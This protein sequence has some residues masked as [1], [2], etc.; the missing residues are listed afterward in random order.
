MTIIIA[1]FSLGGL[2]GEQLPIH[3]DGLADMS[4]SKIKLSPLPLQNHEPFQSERQVNPPMLDDI[5]IDEHANAVTKHSSPVTMNQSGLSLSQVQ[6]PLLQAH[7]PILSERHGNPS[8][9]GE[10]PSNGQT[11][12]L[13]KHNRSLRMDQSDLGLSLS[14]SLS[15]DGL[16]VSQQ[17]KIL[18]SVWKFADYFQ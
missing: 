16:G 7:E 14:R 2:L 17:F 10:V 15:D 1:D 4:S 8:L 12:T 9:L 13:P 11:K 18:I 3:P 6:F 5:Q